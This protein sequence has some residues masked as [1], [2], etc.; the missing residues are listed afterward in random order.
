MRTRRWTRSESVGGGCLAS[1][2]VWEQ[3]S[4][5][6]SFISFSQAPSDP[7]AC[8]EVCVVCFNLWHVWFVSQ[9]LVSRP[10]QE[11]SVTVLSRLLWQVD[12]ASG[13]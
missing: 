10:A 9:K 2:S 11:Q 3:T 4:F 6:T 8:S 5:F 12:F 13:E 7:S 1:L